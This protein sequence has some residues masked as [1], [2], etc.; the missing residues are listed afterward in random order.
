LEKLQQ[1]GT[2]HNLIKTVKR[3]PVENL[4]IVSW[5]ISF[6]LSIF[7]F[8]TLV[9]LKLNYSKVVS[10]GNISVDLPSLKTLHLIKVYFKNNG[11]FN[12]LL[13][14]CPILQDLQT[15]HI[16]YLYREEGVR[17]KTLSKLMRANIDASDVPVKAIYNVQF[18]QLKVRYFDTKFHWINIMYCSLL[19]SNFY[20]V[21]FNC[22][23]WRW[24]LN[25]ETFFY[26]K[27]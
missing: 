5:Y 22:R 9:V 6:P 19:S 14:G 17:L 7:I 18:L 10:I 4:H 27:T 23:C 15:D 20:T 21:T 25:I 12:K 16:Y 2:F 1:L 3:H 24:L 11:N 8:P 13:N 26:F